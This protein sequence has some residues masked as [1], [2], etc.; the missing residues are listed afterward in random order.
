MGERSGPD[1][2]HEEELGIELVG[3]ERLHRI[4]ELVERLPV[5][6]TELHR[7]RRYFA[8]EADA[9]FTGAEVVARQRELATRV[10]ELREALAA[11]ATPSF[12]E[13]AFPLALDQ[14][15]YV[16]DPAG[17]RRAL[18]MEVEYRVAGGETRRASV[19]E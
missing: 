1:V 5:E 12:V 10:T 8:A 16:D 15:F 17:T 19:T 6:L 14:L 4:Q 13:V 11:G 3:D 18:T 2:L 7:E 9:E